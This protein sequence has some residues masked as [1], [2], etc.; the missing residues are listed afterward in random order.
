MEI[1]MEMDM[2]MDMRGPSGVKSSG[3]S[4][5][6]GLAHR[7]VTVSCYSYGRPLDGQLRRQRRRPSYKPSNTI[8]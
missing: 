4:R 7:K 8:S 2:D 3:S 6:L 1:R 5:E